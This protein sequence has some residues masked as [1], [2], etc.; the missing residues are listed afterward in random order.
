MDVT[1]DNAHSLANFLKSGPD[2]GDPRTIG[3]YFAARRAPAAFFRPF[4]VVDTFRGFRLPRRLERVVGSGPS[5]ML[6]STLDPTSTIL[7]YRWSRLRSVR[8]RCS[9]VEM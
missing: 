5:V 1:I 8:A 4:L 3:D 2:D 7:W 6:K 9:R